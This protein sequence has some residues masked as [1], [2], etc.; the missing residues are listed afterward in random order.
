MKDIEG[1]RITPEEL[2]QHYHPRLR[3]FVASFAKLPAADHEDIVSEILVK[4]IEKLETYNPM[5]SL[6]TWVYNIAKNH[7]V[8]AIRKTGR[9]I[10]VS[11]ESLDERVADQPDLLSDIIARD[12]LDECKRIIGTLKERDK[13][14][15]FL[16]Y[17]EGLN[18]KEIA[19][20]E[21][22]NANTVRQRLMVIKAHIKKQ[23]GGNYET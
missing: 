17:Y 2:W 7:C 15:I 18:S 5:Y 8:D 4:A 12:E 11:P 1:Q 14:L 13:R 21:G 6:S 22:I 20:M 23:M 9:E 19:L 10:A 3:A 16:S